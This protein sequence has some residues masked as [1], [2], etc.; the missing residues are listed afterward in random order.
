MNIRIQQEALPETGISELSRPEGVSSSGAGRTR[1]ASDP[2]GPEG[3][4]VE[5]SALSGS[6]ADN[7]AA[8]AAQQSAKVQHLAALYANDQYHVDSARVSRSLVEQAIGPVAPG[9]GR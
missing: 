4:R 9:D 2:G 6:I 5:I 1:S 3:D 8:S 7:M